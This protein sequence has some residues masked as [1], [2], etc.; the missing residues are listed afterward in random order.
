MRKTI[1]SIVIGTI[2]LPIIIAVAVVYTK[3]VNE[4]EQLVLS[5]VIAYLQNDNIDVDLAQ[6]NIVKPGF[7]TGYNEWYVKR[8]DTNEKYQ[9]QNGEVVK[10]VD[11]ME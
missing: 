9:Y 5:E 7:F 2:L 11:D 6:L 10:I 4:K 8:V 1:T 3:N